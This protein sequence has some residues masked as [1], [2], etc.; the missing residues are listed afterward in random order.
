[1]YDIPVVQDY[2]TSEM[3]TVR[4]S[5]GSIEGH[6]LSTL[7][8]EEI[9]ILNIGQHRGLFP[10]LNDTAWRHAIERLTAKGWLE[11]IRRG[12]YL[13]VPRAGVMGWEEHPFLVAAAIA[14]YDYYVSFWSALVHYGLTEQ[15]P[16]VVYIA[17]SKGYSTE[18]RF[19]H[20]RYRIV[21]LSPKRFFGRREEMIRNH[22]VWLAKPEKA[23]LD[24]LYQEQYGG[25]IVEIAK[26]LAR[27]AERIDTIHLTDYAVQM[28]SNALCRRLGYL[29]E[30]VGLPD[31]ERLHPHLG[32]TPQV[33]LSRLLPKQPAFFD[34]RWRL[35]VNITREDLLSWRETW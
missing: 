19:K 28:D 11:P 23:L 30:M 26:A 31:A 33:Y 5:L 9:A 10:D 8:L 15:R 6:I 34:K 13:V 17:Q 21:R 29:M 14:T 18:H 20:W 24:S 12:R 25:G 22:S 2:R 4:P 3:H 16:R 27:A 1:M 32:R 7:D 35:Y